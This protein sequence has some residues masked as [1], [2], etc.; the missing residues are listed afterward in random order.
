MTFCDPYEVCGT[1][2]VESSSTSGRSPPK[3]A[4]ELAK[5]RRGGAAQRRAASSTARTP[6]RFTRMP[7]SKSASAAPD[8]TA[9]RW[10]IASVSGAIAREANTGSETSPASVSRRAS[11]GRPGKAWSASTRRSIRAWVPSAPASVPRASRALASRVPMKPPPPVMTTFMRRILSAR[12]L[13]LVVRRRGRA[14]VDQLV[15]RDFHGKCEAGDAGQEKAQQGALEVVAVS[16]HTRLLPQRRDLRDQRVDVDRLE[17]VV[18]RALAQP[19]QAVGRAVLGGA[20]EHG[21][22]ARRFVARDGARRLEAVGARH[23]DVHEDEVG[24]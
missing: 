2:V 13:L 8:T 3:A 7:R 16:A 1:G 15:Q 10:K 21:D 19:P 5:T 18:A 17:H 9:A 20:D 4:T 12:L 23:D 11:F 22:V 24:A 14:A 6:P